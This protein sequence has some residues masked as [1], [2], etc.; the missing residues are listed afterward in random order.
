MAL[1]LAFRPTFKICELQRDT[2]EWRLRRMLQFSR[3]SDNLRPFS[4]TMNAARP[5]HVVWATG[6]SSHPALVCALIN[7]CRW[8]DFR[9]AKELYISGFSLTGWATDTGLWRLRPG[10]E[11]DLA[12]AH[13]TPPAVFM[14]QNAARHR[15]V[16]RNLQSRFNREHNNPEFMADCT[17]AF[18]ASM[19]EVAAGTA[20]G[21]FS[22][23]HAEKIFGYGRIRVIGRH[24]VWQGPKPRAVDDAR[25]NGL[26]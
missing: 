25:A 11:N 21:P 3:I 20:K 16:I 12:D 26:N 22:V 24:V 23:S 13:M 1:N 17:A 6:E 5:Q 4:A 15:L 9:L 8:P 7:A 2:P 14:E 19:A 10:T 18:S